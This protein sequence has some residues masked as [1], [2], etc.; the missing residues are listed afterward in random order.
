M[1]YDT[2]LGVC[3][4][5][6]TRQRVAPTVLTL[7]CQYTVLVI[8]SHID[9]RGAFSSALNPP[10]HKLSILQPLTYSHAVAIETVSPQASRLLLGYTV[11]AS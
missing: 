2:R 8:A 11:S 1:R 4:F 5:G 10:P 7:S 6:A 3:V 9:T